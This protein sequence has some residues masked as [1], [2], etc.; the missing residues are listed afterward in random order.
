MS[1]S[2]GSGKKSE[3]GKESGGT[4]RGRRNGSGNGR[5]K[6]SESGRETETKTA[7]AGPENESETETGRETEAVK[8]APTAADPGDGKNLMSQTSQSNNKQQSCAVYRNGSVKT[9]PS[10]LK[11]QHTHAGVF[12]HY[13]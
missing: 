2:G 12:T 3:S 9:F 1:A 13:N 8:G 4:A 6:G 7:T 11:P 5:G 10:C